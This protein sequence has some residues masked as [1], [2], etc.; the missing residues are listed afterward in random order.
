MKRSMFMSGVKEPIV[1][2]DSSTESLSVWFGAIFA[3]FA[4]LDAFFSPSPMRFT[5]YQERQR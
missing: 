3:I 4:V 1:Y 5:R 2:G